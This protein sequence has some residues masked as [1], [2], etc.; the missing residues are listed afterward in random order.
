MKCPYCIESIDFEGYLE[1]PSSCL[2][3]DL[4]VKVILKR[5]HQY[6]YQVQQQM[7]TTELPFCDFVV[8][9]FEAS[10]S[11]FIHERITPDQDHWD[12]VL[13]R[14]SKFW[15]YCVFPEI[16]GRWYTRK[17]YL[18]KPQLNS[19]TKIC[20][21]DEETGEAT[22]K[23]Q[24]VDCPISLYHPLCLKV[25]EFSNNWYCP[26]CQRLPDFK[27]QPKAKEIS[28]TKALAL[29]NVCICHQ[30]AKIEDKI[31][32]CHN[33]CCENGKFF[34]ISCLGYRRKPNN[35]K[36]TWQCDK[37]KANPQNQIESQVGRITLSQQSRV[38]EHE[39]ETDDFENSILIKDSPDR[40]MFLEESGDLVLMKEARG[41]AERYAQYQTLNER[42]FELVM[43]PNCWL[44]CDIIHQVH[45]YLRNS[46]PAIEGFQRPTLGPFRNFSIVGG[47]FVQI[48]HTGDSHWVCISSIGG[49]P[50]MLSLYDSL[51]N[52]VVSNEIEEKINS[53]IGADIF[54]GVNVVPV[55][56][57]QNG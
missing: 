20:F 57:Q 48:L 39:R 36:T 34:H 22:V 7:F 52:H 13:P 50:G 15:Q 30:K 24:N 17:C 42:H 44:D 43:S 16:L 54:K 10:Q 12:R 19:G 28:T 4:D 35:S 31:I 53:L 1:N 49:L 14:L 26:H 46:N 9:G 21:C 51:Y 25:T 23:C 5:S 33:P 47:E 45:V 2:V 8:F 6:F 3:K 29:E 41:R 38:K 32:E 18:L 55:Q 27:R 40:E 37:C 11:A 56:Q